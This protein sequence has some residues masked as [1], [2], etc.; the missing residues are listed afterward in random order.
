ME[1]LEQGKTIEQ[2][3]QEQLALEQGS[4]ADE[5]QELDER[6]SE[7]TERA[8]QMKADRR[9]VAEN[10]DRNCSKNIHVF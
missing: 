1:A 2:A 5:I 9:R 10:C 7:L 8:D 3:C 6:L 4:I